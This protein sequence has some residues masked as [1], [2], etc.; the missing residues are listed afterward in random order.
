MAEDLYPVPA[1]FAAKAKVDAARYA[2][3][4][5]RSLNDA[6]AY[7]LEQAKR[8]DWVKAPT[9]ANESSF[10]EADFGIKWFADGQLNVSANCLDRHLSERGDQIAIIWEPDDPAE[11]PKTFTYAQMH[12]EVCRMANVLKDL[13]EQRGDQIGRAHV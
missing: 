11:E 4:Y 1:D 5:D 8:L 10:N 9:K 2:A 12:A 13:G 6:D 7:W 3:D